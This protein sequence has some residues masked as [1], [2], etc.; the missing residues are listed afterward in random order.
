[1]VLYI[2]GGAGFQPQDLCSLNVFIG[3]GYTQI[4]RVVYLIQL[5]YRGKL[6][7]DN[8]NV[9]SS[10]NAWRSNKIRVSKT[11]SQALFIFPNNDWNQ[12]STR[13]WVEPKRKMN[14]L[15]LGAKCLLPVLKEIRG[16]WAHQLLVV[17]YWIILQWAVACWF[18]DFLNTVWYKS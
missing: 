14:E 3:R 7:T 9:H 10:Q 4:P 18:F 12:H 17:L 1:M 8:L 6:W 5:C 11:F 16:T 13:T 2:P 15:G